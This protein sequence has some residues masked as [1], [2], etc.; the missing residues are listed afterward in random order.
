MERKVT[1]KND[2]ILKEFINKFNL[3]LVNTTVINN[4]ILKF[5]EQLDT[6]YVML[7]A[8]K[9]TVSTTMEENFDLPKKD[10]DKKFLKIY[11]EILSGKTP[12]QKIYLKSVKE[13]IQQHHEL[14]E[15]I[16]TFKNKTDIAEA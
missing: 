13:L 9:Y 10:F 6:V 11:K 3:I 1:E 16:E 5:A 8:L 12:M 15:L 14:V 4:T 7:G 2:E